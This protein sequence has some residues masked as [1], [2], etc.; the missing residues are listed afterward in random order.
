VRLAAL[1][2]TCLLAAVC[3]LT[4]AALRPARAEP[5]RTVAETSDYKATSLHADVVEFCEKLAKESPLVRLGTLGTS[6]EGRK[7]P[8][9]IVADPP[10]ATAAEAQKGKKLVVFAMGNIHAGEVDGKEAL[11]A[12]ARDIVTAKD[13]P[14]LKDLVLVFAPIFNADGNEK[15]DKA[16]RPTQAGPADG[17]GVRTNAQGFDLNRD[18]VKLESPEVRALVRFFNE[19]DPAVFIDCHTTN[20]SYHRY[21]MTYEGGGCPAGDQRIVNLVRD[22][23]LPDVGRR[24]EKETGF[25]SYF[26]GNFSADRTRWETVPPT[27]RYST[28]YFGLRNRVGVLSESYTYAPFKDR[29]RGSYGFVNAIFEYAA[30]NKEKLAKLLA[31]AR[32]DATR[33]GK[34]PKAADKVVLRSKPAPVGRP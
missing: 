22:G 12:L 20:G 23:L 31:D 2:R 5:P 34:E 25:R 28:H 6:Q 17:V 13:R 9:V 24:L 32:D 18:F 21:T 8:L 14:L 27:P 33:A 7:L 3:L 4:T 11:L 1:P 26:Y 19:W 29:V 16:H 10:V 30:Q 15:I